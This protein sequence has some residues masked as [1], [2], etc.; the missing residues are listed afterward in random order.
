MNHEGRWAAIRTLPA[1]TVV[2]AAML[3]A[4]PGFGQQGHPLAG[5]WH[6]EWGPPDDRMDL[7]IIMNWDGQRVTGLV[8]PVTDRTQ[9]GLGPQNALGFLELRGSAIGVRDDAGPG[10]LIAGCDR[11]R[12]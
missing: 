6:G 8:N 4:S 5:S 12:D 2:A 1:V 3:A 7:T 9:A 11:R 10:L